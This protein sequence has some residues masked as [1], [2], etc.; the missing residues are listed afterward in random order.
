MGKDKK[1]LLG[2]KEMK[3]PSQNIDFLSKNVTPDFSQRK[4]KKRHKKKDLP[5]WQTSSS[6]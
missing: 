4:L 2:L 3:L 6:N 5:N 1:P